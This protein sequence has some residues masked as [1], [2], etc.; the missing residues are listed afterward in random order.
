[1]IKCI[2]LEDE[3]MAQKNLARH[4]DKHPDVELIGI[5]DSAEK[6]INFLKE[7]EVD[8]VF[9][10]VELP[11]VDG[12]E[13]LETSPVIPEVIFTTAKKEYAFDAFEY[14]A[15]DFLKK[16][17]SYGKFEKAIDKYKKK[18]NSSTALTTGSAG[19]KGEFEDM[20]VK[21][22]GK[23][24]RII[25]DDIYFIENVGD[26]V[27]IVTDNGSFITHN[28]IK[29]VSAKLE[30]THFL[31]VHR[32]YIVNLNKIVDIEDGTLLIKDKVIP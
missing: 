17:I 23:L 3:L 31:K 30:Q 18:V 26:Y 1:M 12:I 20:F 27:K 4:C 13:F 2:I 24:V 29:S 25:L 15:V 21:V 22:N 10:D 5:Y 16:P 6:A 9:L 8:L 11:D 32:S 28:T 7:N 19:A 14:E